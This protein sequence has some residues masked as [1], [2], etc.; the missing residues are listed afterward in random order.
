MPSKNRTNLEQRVLRAAEEVHSVESEF[1]TA[2]DARVSAADEKARHEAVAR[3]AAV[4][5]RLVAARERLTDAKRALAEAQGDI[6]RL[7]EATPP[8]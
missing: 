6:Y 3:A 4:S 2:A 7:D 8:I 5:S 1:E